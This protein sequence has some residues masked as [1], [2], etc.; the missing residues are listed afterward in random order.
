MNKFVCSGNI[1]TKPEYRESDKYKMV[2]FRMAV[3][4]SWG[5]GDDQRYTEWFSVTSWQ[6]NAKWLSE[7]LKV[8]D[9]VL[10]SG[11]IRSRTYQVEGKDRFELKLE[12][13][14]VEPCNKPGATEK[15][16]DEF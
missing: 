3:N 12:Q 8:G 9:K 5:P 4:E 11:R 15:S 1:A 14:E 10:V 16:R 6:G 7:N 13:C 2:T